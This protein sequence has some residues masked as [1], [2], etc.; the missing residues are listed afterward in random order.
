M[1]IGQIAAAD[2][3]A[4]IAEWPVPFMYG[5]V[6]YI[7]TVSGKN[8]RRPLEIG[9]FQ[10]EPEVTIVIN[11]KDAAGNPT[12]AEA[13]SIGDDIIIGNTRYAVDRTELDEFSEAL[14]LDLRSPTR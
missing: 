1:T 9:G 10:T 2:L 4:M 13:P 6:E 7:G 11:L 5:G 8:T 12:F 3:R 14:Q